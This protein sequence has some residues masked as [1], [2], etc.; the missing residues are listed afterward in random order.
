MTSPIEPAF[1]ATPTLGMPHVWPSPHSSPTFEGHVRSTPMPE[2]IS[3]TAIT[4]QPQAK[5]DGLTKKPSLIARRPL[6]SF[7][8]LAAVFSWWPW[9]LYLAY[10]AP[11]PIIAFGPFIA[12]LVVLGRT[13]GRGGVGDLLR[14]MIH[15]RVRP[16]IYLAA[17]GLPILTQVVAAAAERGCWRGGHRLIRRSQRRQFRADVPRLP[18]DPGGWRNVG[19]AGAGA[20]TRS[21]T[22]KTAGRAS[23]RLLVPV[24]CGALASPLDGEWPRSRGWRWPTW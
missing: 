3:A 4:S 10:L 2:R 11:Y 8:V 7:V 20:A 14:S 18:A 22:C 13:R 6:L 9:P 19:G 15:W 24:C 5:H 12:A 23:S 17:L 1:G 16:V 21:R